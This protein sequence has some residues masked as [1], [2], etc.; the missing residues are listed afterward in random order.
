MPLAFLKLSFL[1]DK[2]YHPEI[3]LTVFLVLSSVEETTGN[4][5]SSILNLLTLDDILS[6]S[7]F[8]S[9]FNQ[10]T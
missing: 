3:G 1:L 8:I 2:K 10:L 4:E 6:A 5:F 7:N 9:S